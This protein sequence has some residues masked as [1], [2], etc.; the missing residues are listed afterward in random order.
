MVPHPTRRRFAPALLLPL[1]LACAAPLGAEVVRLKT[2]E[3]VKCRPIQARSDDRTVVLEDL[4]RGTIRSLAWEALEPG[5]RDRLQEEWGWKGRRLSTVKGWRLVTRVGDDEQE[6][7]GVIEREEGG[8]VGVRRNGDIQV[9][10]A[11]M[12]V[13]RTE[14]NHD[15]REVYS[16][17]QLMDQLAAELAA[18]APPTTLDSPDGRTAWR[19]AE[20]AEWVGALQQALEAYRR[21]AVDPEFL[22]RATAE[23]RALRVEALLKD[24]AAV[25]T[26]R[27]L[28]VK[29][30]SN[31]FK[32]VRA[33]LEG[34][35]AKHPGA[36]EAVV[37]ARDAFKAQVAQRRD[38]YFRQMARYEFARKIC[39]KLIEAK[40]REKDITL[41]DVRSWVKRD[42][43]NEA[44]AALAERMGKADVVTPEEVRGWWDTRWEG[45]LK[46]S[47]SRAGYGGG[48]FIIHKPQIAP[49]KPRNSGG[50]GGRAGGGG[51]AGPAPV[52]PIPKPPT[53]DEWWAKA[54][55]SERASWVLAHFVVSS[56][57]FEV[58]DDV[59]RTPCI[60][61]LGHGIITKTTQ[62]GELLQYLCNR[63]GGAR[64]DVA[65]K[66]R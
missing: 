65:V 57:L 28:K 33:G 32:A 19:V 13:E 9:I 27:D 25:A 29:L 31:L 53:A 42:L 43:P 38:K 48:T 11:E 45:V 35:D 55:T 3:A 16:A 4:Q 44:F 30:S 7:Y 12:I 63:C 26:L 15:P 21:A 36:S 62:T 5:D 17:P 47:W 49:P 61:C 8:K 56:Q 1:L 59:D 41:S 6:I 39:R 51:N 14:E 34:F 37:K 46:S 22:Q 64:D 40:V 18:Q 60:L 52:I 2:G 24:Q 54:P 50:G 58:S 23:Q 66:F 20:Y 10:P